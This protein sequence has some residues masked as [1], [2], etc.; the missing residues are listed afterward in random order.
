MSNR[1]LFEG[2]VFDESG[3]PVKVT[4]IGQEAFYVVDDAGFLRHIPCLD[5]DQ[6]VWD[7]LTAHIEGN[8]T[9]LSEQAAKMMGQEDI[10]TIAMIQNQ[11]KNREQ[12][13]EAL[14]KVG[15]PE[16]SRAYMGMMGFKI[17]IDLHGDIVEFNQPGIEDPGEE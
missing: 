6:Q 5:V 4:R 14:S 1:A 15:I 7:R 17:V 11:L 12:Q 16:D 2:L 9:L 10:F 8:E 13:F 3:N